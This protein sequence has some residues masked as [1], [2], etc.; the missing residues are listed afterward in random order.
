[1]SV[2]DDLTVTFDSLFIEFDGE[3]IDSSAPGP[4]PIT[5]DWGKTWAGPRF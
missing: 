4:I 3:R 2:M 1:M 5:L